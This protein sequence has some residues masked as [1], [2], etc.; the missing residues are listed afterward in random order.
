M[1]ECKRGRRGD[2]KG[3][4]GLMSIAVAGAAILAAT[5]CGGCLY[6]AI[7]AM[8]GPSTTYQQP[9]AGQQG[10]IPTAPAQQS[11]DQ[12]NQNKQQTGI[13]PNGAQPQGEGGTL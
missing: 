8:A 5:V 11:T 7:P 3:D 10:S 12:T 1:M 6:T 4:N 13:P 2:G 9:A